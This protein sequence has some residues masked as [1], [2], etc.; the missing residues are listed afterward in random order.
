[1]IARAAAAEPSQNR[2][3][4]F[5]RCPEIRIAI[6]DELIEIVVENP[7]GDHLESKRC[8]A[9]VDSPAIQDGFSGTQCHGISSSMAACGQPLTKHVSKSIK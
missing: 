9:T 2:R 7:G 8:S 4:P 3:N 6:A 5:G 1:M